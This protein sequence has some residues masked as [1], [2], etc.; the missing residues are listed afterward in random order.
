MYTGC[1]D[2]DAD[3]RMTMGRVGGRV[4]ACGRVDT[5]VMC[6]R[7]CRVN[8]CYVH[9]CELSRGR[10]DYTELFVVVVHVV[11]NISV[12]VE[13]GRCDGKK[14]TGFGYCIPAI[15]CGN[16]SV[17]IGTNKMEAEM[18]LRSGGV[19]KKCGRASRRRMELGCRWKEDAQMGGASSGRAIVLCASDDVRYLECGWEKNQRALPI[20]Y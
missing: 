15:G 9:G 13:H 8:V 11:C 20:Q 4:V 1:A 16:R 2:F 19:G 3:L 10:M 5:W 12:N 18:I 17:V 6:C 7:C 14:A